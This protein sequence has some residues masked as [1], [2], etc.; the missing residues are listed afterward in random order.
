MWNSEVGILK[1]LW[2]LVLQGAVSCLLCSGSQWS[3]LRWRSW[4]WLHIR[5]PWEALG[6]TE[7]KALP[8]GESDTTGLGFC[9]VIKN[10]LSF[11]VT[12]MSSLCRQ[13]RTETLVALRVTLATHTKLIH[14]QP[15]GPEPLSSQVFLI[16]HL[17]WWV[18]LNGRLLHSFLINAMVLV[19]VHCYRATEGPISW[20]TYRLSAL[21]LASS[22][23][24]ASWYLHVKDK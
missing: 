7:A 3:N 10:V 20:A 19:W 14:A 12:L 16:V 6:M 8:L 15:T 18:E 23:L 1:E 11:Q 9:L 13:L 5:T 24:H 2:A 21:S 22:L 4:P 17:N